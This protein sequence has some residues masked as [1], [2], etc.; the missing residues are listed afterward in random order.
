MVLSRLA[1]LSLGS[2][3][4][5]TALAAPLGHWGQLIPGLVGMVFAWWCL[6][7]IDAATTPERRPSTRGAR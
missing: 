6:A 5:F 4:M 1:M 2:V 3:S 7:E